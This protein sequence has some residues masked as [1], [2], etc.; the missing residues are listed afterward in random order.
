M[1]VVQEYDYSSSLESG[2]SS[3]GARGAI[4]PGELNAGQWGMLM[5]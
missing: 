4:L 1:G 2:Y 3:Y 5:G